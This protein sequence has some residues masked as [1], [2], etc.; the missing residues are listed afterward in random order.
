MPRIATATRT[1]KATSS[2]RSPCRHPAI[3]YFAACILGKLVGDVL[4]TR[5]EI[6][7]LMADLLCTDSPPT[8]QTRLTDWAKQ[9]ADSLGRRYAHE[10]VRRRDRQRAYDAL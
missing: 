5:D 8:G 9:H 10:L 6:R 2:G 3:G 7:G 4:L 1:S